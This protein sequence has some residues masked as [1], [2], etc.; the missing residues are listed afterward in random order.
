MATYCFKCPRCGAQVQVMDLEPRVCGACIRESSFEAIVPLM[1]DYRAESVGMAVVGLK[2]ERERG[3]ASAVRDLFL[4]TA[5]ELAGPGDPDG[6]KA[7]RQW[8]D[9]HDPKPGNS[10]PLRPESPRTV[11]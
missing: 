3:G 11:Y 6:H 7:I 9:E 1:R 8:N 10:R 2:R 5:K 4:P